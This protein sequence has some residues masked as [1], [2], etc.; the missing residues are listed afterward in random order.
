M[1][2]CQSTAKRQERA[3]AALLHYGTGLASFVIAAG[4]VVQGLHPLPFD[5]SGS[6]LMNAGV[7]LFILLPIARVA[8]ML[9]Q[10]ARA[11]DAAYVAISALVLAI[12]GAGFLAG[13]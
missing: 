10:F 2:E 12:I 3:I 8:L 9:I 13:I 4:L 11:R 5:L 7:A 6:S 1:G